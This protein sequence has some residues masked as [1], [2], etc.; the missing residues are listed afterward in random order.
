M[1][2]VR[3]VRIAAFP[4]K[5]TTAKLA[6]ITVWL[7]LGLVEFG[8]QPDKVG[9]QIWTIGRKLFGKASCYLILDHLDLSIVL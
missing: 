4:L 5:K 7:Q 8:F 2:R 1:K 3:V 9:V 6:S